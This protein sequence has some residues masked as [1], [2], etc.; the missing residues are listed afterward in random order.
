MSSS[1]ALLTT[2]I[3]YFLQIYIF[4]LVVRILLTWFPTV[5]W[6]NQ[7]T[8]T[9]SPLTDPYLDLFRSFIPPLG[10][11]LDISPMLAIF[12]LQIVA[13]LFTPAISSSV[14]F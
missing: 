2:S 5:E 14:G 4:L 13:G 9:L 6:M 12:L 7:I 10:G 1:A 11:T 8:A 3:Y